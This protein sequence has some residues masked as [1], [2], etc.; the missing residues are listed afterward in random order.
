MCC[1]RVTRPR[2]EHNLVVFES[3]GRRHNTSG[4]Y[5]S[6]SKTKKLEGI[7]V[8]SAL[9]SIADGSTVDDELALAGFPEALDGGF[10]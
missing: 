7:G 1:A 3:P 6:I 4:G 9:P 8:N 2:L 5:R 10:G